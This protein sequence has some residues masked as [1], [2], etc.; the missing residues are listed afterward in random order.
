[1]G[2]NLRVS[3][4]IDVSDDVAKRMGLIRED[5]FNLTVKDTSSGGTTERFLNLSVKKSS[6]R[7]DNVLKQESKLI[8]WSGDW[9]KEDSLP[10]LQKIKTAHAAAKDLI[11]AKKADPPNPDVIKAAE[12][13][14]TEANKELHDDITKAEQK[15]A[16][17]KNAKPQVPAD[18]TAAETA[19][20]NAQ[21][22]WKFRS[23]MVFCG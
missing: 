1:V 9:P 16:E 4:D 14:L 15:L 19:L 12:K 18:I 5:L 10:K 6:R 22:P 20:K 8:R 23:R 21:K 11:V 17:A 2:A 13:V 3:V 7:I